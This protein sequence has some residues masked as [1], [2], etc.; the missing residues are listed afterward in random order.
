MIGTYIFKSPSLLSSAP[1]DSAIS[2]LYSDAIGSELICINSGLF[3]S[4]NFI[5]PNSMV[6]VKRV[7]IFTNQRPG[8]IKQYSVSLM[9][10]SYFILSYG[11]KQKTFEIPFLNSWFDVNITFD[12]SNTMNKL[13]LKRLA[14]LYNQENLQSFYLGKNFIPEFFIEVEA[15]GV[16]TLNGELV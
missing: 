12:P 15:A 3:P 7:L 2:G 14:F 1:F 8:L 10:D 6:K 5:N 9:L 13:S 11:G 4:P 16:K